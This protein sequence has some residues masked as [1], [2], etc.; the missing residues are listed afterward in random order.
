[1]SDSNYASQV[2]KDT[3]LMPQVSMRF[4]FGRRVKAVITGYGV[5][6]KI[7][8]EV[9]E[10]FRHGVLAEEKEEEEGR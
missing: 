6:G 1:M 5:C 8:I 9:L 10:D 3:V 2:E 4:G 7:W